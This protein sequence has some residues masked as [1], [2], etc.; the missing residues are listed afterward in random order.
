MRITRKN[1]GNITECLGNTRRIWNVEC[2][3]EDDAK[4]V[5]YHTAHVIVA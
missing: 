4:Y 3:P 5:E 2:T 1:E